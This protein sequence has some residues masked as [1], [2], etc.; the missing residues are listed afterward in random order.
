MKFIAWFC[1]L[2]SAATT[3]FSQ[4]NS[5]LRIG[6]ISIETLDVYSSDEATRGRFYQLADK[7]HSETHPSVVRGFLLFKEGD[8]YDPALLSETER[9]LRALGFLKTA[10][11]TAG[12]PHDGVVDVLVQT[13]DAWSIE[14][15]TQAGNK[16]GVGTFGISLTDNNLAGFGRQASISFNKG[17]DRNR[18]AIDYRD[19]AFF[20]PYWQSRLTW[21]R[22]SD[23]FERRLSI[24][25]PFYSFAT[26]WSTQFSFDSTRQSDRLYSAARLTDVF[27]RQ[28]RRLIASIGY[29]IHPNEADAM[30]VIVGLRKVNDNFFHLRHAPGASLPDDRNFNY[31][32]LRF[33]RVENDFL[34][35]NFI[36]KDLRYE[37]FNL[38]QQF[39]VEGAVSP[40]ASGQSSSTEYV[41]VAE[42]LGR[43]IGQNTFVL[44][45]IAFESRIDH[46]LRNSILSASARYVHRFDTEIPQTFVGRILLN[47]GWKL[48]R[49]VQFFADGA[50]G[51]RGYRLHSFEGSRNLI[52][53]LEQRLFLGRE[54]L[55]IVSPGV[56]A[57]VDVGTATDRSLLSASRLKSDVGVGIR[58]G[59]P[60]SPRNLLRI[61]LAY[62]LNRD[63]F[64]RRGLLISFSSGQAF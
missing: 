19:P 49:D 50:E 48:D 60:R 18:A 38:G 45:S 1:L 3:A 58:L 13:Q 27:Q 6:T 51:L 33:E 26:P 11:V 43:T 4:P 9:N 54:L 30:R 32:F 44:P 55:Q 7:L 41:R 62:A 53:N 23:G 46:G 25:R 40:R 39:S 31:L 37:D 2:I 15:G 14:P 35:V 63:P 20:R 21:A 57:F 8:P 56:V 59:L 52:L 24:G 61:D 34:K 5:I 29:A 22:N 42:T 36:D 28:H 17:T 12:P 10:S 64:G 16:G 47:S